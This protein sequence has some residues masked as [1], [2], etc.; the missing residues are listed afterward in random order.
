M[1]SKRRLVLLF[2]AGL[3]VGITLTVLGAT[4]TP[5][6]VAPATPHGTVR[7]HAVWPGDGPS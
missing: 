3:V 4:A 7:P 1:K 6:P 2:A 5:A